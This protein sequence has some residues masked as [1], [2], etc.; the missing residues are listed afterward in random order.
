MT[1]LSSS[2]LYALIV[3]VCILLAGALFSIYCF[4]ELRPG[5]IGDCV[6]TEVLNKI[7]VFS[8]WCLFLPS[9]AIIIGLVLKLACIKWLAILWDIVFLVLLALNFPMLLV[10]AAPIALYEGVCLFCEPV[11]VQANSENIE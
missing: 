8:L 1:R 9:L 10:G 2:G 6:T 11:V 4:V 5:V 7:E 3:R